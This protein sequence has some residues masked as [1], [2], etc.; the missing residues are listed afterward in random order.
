MQD[1]GLEAPL[2]AWRVQ[3]SCRS[4]LSAHAARYWRH[5]QQEPFGDKEADAPT[6]F[7][8]G[9]VISTDLLRL[10]HSFIFRGQMFLE[11]CPASKHDFQKYR[12][13]DISLS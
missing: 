4:W 13:A 12:T 6:T 2:L 9:A 7:L 3:E 5:E 1:S 10:F 8:N 11:L